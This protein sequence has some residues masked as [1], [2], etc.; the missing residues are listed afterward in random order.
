[1]VT[2]KFRKPFIVFSSKKVKVTDEEN[3]LR[4]YCG[5]YYDSWSEVLWLK[6]IENV[7]LFDEQNHLLADSKQIERA[8]DKWQ[9]AYGV[10]QNHIATIK[11]T[12]KIDTHMRLTVHYN[13]KEAVLKND[14]GSNKTI[15]E[16]Q[17]EELAQMKTKGISLTNHEI[18]YDP[19][20]LDMT[21]ELLVT[22][23]YTFSLTNARK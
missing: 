14:L 15:L 20:K 1:M 22:A 3:R 6:K 7:C 19:Q 5:K 17:G 18:T 13:G 4:F 10:E 21:E 8:R 11:N 12:G 16:H 9:V 23:F 2:L